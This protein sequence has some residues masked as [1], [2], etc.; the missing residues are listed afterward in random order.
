MAVREYH[1]FATAINFTYVC[2]DCGN[3]NTVDNM[4]VPSP[5][6]EA[7]AHSMSVN[8]SEET[9][10]CEECGQEFSVELSTGIYG[11]EIQIDDV[12]VIENVQERIPGE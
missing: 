1:P 12:E 10:K 9:V 11:G 8:S 7:E 6:W 4:T 5:N 3:H 2:P